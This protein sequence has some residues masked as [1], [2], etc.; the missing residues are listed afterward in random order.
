MGDARC[1]LAAEGEATMSDVVE[2]TDAEIKR[3]LER[4]RSLLPALDW[5][6]SRETA[7]FRRYLVAKIRLLEG[8]QERRGLTRA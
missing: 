2:L 5:E 8:E 7:N 3:L 1:A 4:Y 6:D